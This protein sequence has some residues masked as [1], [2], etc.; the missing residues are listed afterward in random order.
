MFV[1]LFMLIDEVISEIDE[2]NL[3]C[4]MLCY[5]KNNDKLRYV[6]FE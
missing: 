5:A 3:M 4:F 2:I 6:R 1:N